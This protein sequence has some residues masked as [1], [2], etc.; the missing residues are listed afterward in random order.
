MLFFACPSQ[1]GRYESALRL[2]HCSFWIAPFSS[3]YI[4]ISFIISAHSSMNPPCTTAK[5]ARVLTLKSSS[6]RTLFSSSIAKVVVDM[7]DL[8]SR[9]SC[10]MASNRRMTFS[11]HSAVSRSNSE[12]CGEAI[13][14]GSVAVGVVVFAPTAILAEALKVN[15]DLSSGP[16]PARTE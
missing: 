7:V 11:R 8:M 6:C 15:G 4:L 16:L 10:S 3:Y 12:L 14:H 2:V 1:A 9:N 13:S 5:I